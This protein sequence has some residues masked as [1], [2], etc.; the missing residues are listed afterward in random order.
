LVVALLLLGY[1]GFMG[2]LTYY[3]EV[4]ELLDN[5]ESIS[6]QTVRIS[7]NVADDVVKNGLEMHFTLLDISDNEITLPVVY[8]GAVPD[9]F[10]VGNQIVVEG[11]YTTGIFE[12]EAIIVKCGSKY[13]PEEQN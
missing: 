12:A 11:K 13:I 5:A 3:Y 4:N 1:F 8:S 7:G 2:G 9:T 6:G 10:K